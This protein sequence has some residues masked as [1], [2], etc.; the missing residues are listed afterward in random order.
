MS[1]SRCAGVAF[2]LIAAG[3]CLLLAGCAVLSTAAS[4]QVDVDV[5][6]GP[7]SQSLE[8]QIGDA[9]GTVASGQNSLR[10]FISELTGYYPIRTNEHCKKWNESSKDGPYTNAAWQPR[11]AGTV[12]PL[13]NL[14]Y[15]A[16]RALGFLDSAER[17]LRLQ[18][19][20]R[21][22]AKR[23]LE[24]ALD[25]LDSAAE[26]LSPKD[27]KNQ[28]SIEKQA[29]KL[30]NESLRSLNSGA[31]ARDVAKSFSSGRQAIP[32]PSESR[33]EEIVEQAGNWLEQ[34]ASEPDPQ[35]AF[36]H[37]LIQRATSYLRNRA[38]SWGAEYTGNFLPSQ[39]ARDRIVNF[40]VICARHA[41]LISTRVDLYVV[42]RRGVKPGDLHT[43][44]YLRDASP[45]IY[46]NLYEW[47]G[48]DRDRVIPGGRAYGGTDTR[49]NGM[50]VEDRVRA[51]QAL[52]A[53][54]Y[55]ANVNQVFASGQGEV[56]IALIK[57]D[58]GNWNLKSFDN[59]PEKLL[60]AY[61][62]ATIAGTRAITKIIKD[63]TSPGKGVL[64][65]ASQVS[66]GSVG[67][68]EKMANIE[69]A[70]DKSRVEARTALADIASTLTKQ[71]ETL[72]NAVTTAEKGVTEKK[73]ALDEATRGLDTKTSEL[74]K[75][76]AQKE[77]ASTPARA[78]DPFTPERVKILTE[79]E[80]KLEAE[81]SGLKL[82]VSGA[83]RALE[84]AQDAQK[85]AMEA[86]N[87]AATAAFETARAEVRAHERTVR[88][89][90]TMSTPAE[91]T[92]D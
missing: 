12:L 14:C 45:T 18:L 73:A 40:T 43:K 37:E 13:L 58:I 84:Q 11:E 69:I 48:V 15:D 65:L 52:F 31:P 19:Q 9:L 80:A 85:A 50:T 88:S 66:K 74:E 89:I 17:E 46:L 30:L 64:E 75:V 16:V 49:I 8:V 82:G 38:E 70:V 47:Y 42:Q 20:G 68:A 22:R 54:H 41:E 25:E 44:D 3:L 33:I 83:Q 60:D 24:L 28:E 77:E 35:P 71:R 55:W 61:R 86:R 63:G 90:R 57:D 56:R 91:L 4:L 23:D 21:V 92:E 72:D 27:K 32:A 51:A 39:S 59:N 34:A 62:D 87:N 36:N 81:I 5:Y 53:D 7:L 6:K 79:S 10:L 67:G 78:S 76:R 1:A 2:A 26:N 29:R